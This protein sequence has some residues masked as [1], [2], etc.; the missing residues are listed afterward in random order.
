M[1]SFVNRFVRSLIE[2][3]DHPE[4]TTDLGAVVCWILE[5]HGYEIHQYPYKYE[6]VEVRV[7]KG[8][9]QHGIDILAVKRDAQGVHSYRFVLKQGGMP[10]WPAGKP[11]SMPYDLFT[12]GA[13]PVS[14]FETSYGIAPASMTLVAVHNGDRDKEKVGVLI[15]ADLQRIRDRNDCKTEWWD[16]EKLTSLIMEVTDEDPTTGTSTALFTPR[17]QPFIRLALDSLRPERGRQ[18]AGFD[19]AAIDTLLV[20][21]RESETAARLERR[22]DELGLLVALLEAETERVANGNSLP[23]LETIERILCAAMGRAVVVCPK[24]KRSLRRAF[25]ALLKTYEVVAER[26][27]AKLHAVAHHPTGLALPSRAEPIDYPSR[28]LRLSGYLAVA[29]LRMTQRGRPASARRMAKTLALL[30][31]NNASAAHT[32]LTDDQQIELLLVLELWTAAG[33]HPLVRRTCAK[34]L[35]RLATRRA[36][37]LPLPAVRLRSPLP[38]PRSDIATLVGAHRH[39]RSARMTFDDSASTLV[40]ALLYLNDRLGG[41][42]DATARQ[43]LLQGPPALSLQ[44]WQPPTDAGNRWYTEA[45]E[46]DG[47]AFLMMRSAASTTP[48]ADEFEEAAVA[49]DASMAERNKLAAVDRMGWKQTRT[50]PSMH[51]VVA[52]ARQHIAT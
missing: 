52:L 4:R 19:Y 23:V 25:E 39:L 35:H 40:P 27:R 37:G 2:R 26:L 18:G 16:A 42:F 8:R 6:G 45:I 28:L 11:G 1:K 7:G 33:R 30:W 41:S 43:Q 32:P 47:N 46:H 44:V 29:G 13:L 9:L 49:I 21:V 36:L 17:I 14:Q 15:E 20:P 48:F 51:F 50:P 31:K 3:E 10:S 5:H 12:A 38:M 24:I 22:V 34:I